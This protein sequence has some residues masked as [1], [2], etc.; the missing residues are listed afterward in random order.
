MRLS[1]PD[2]QSVQ[3][4][5]VEAWV[6]EKRDWCARKDSAEEGPGSISGVRGVRVS[7]RL[8][9]GFCLAGNHL[10]YDDGNHDIACHP[11]SIVREDPQ[12][13]Q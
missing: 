10:H 8:T 7:K 11:E 3:T 9:E 2:G 13:L 6:P 12:V 4:M 1:V 5:P